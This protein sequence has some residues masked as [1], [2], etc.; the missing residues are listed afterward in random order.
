M[1]N[2]PESDPRKENVVIYDLS[3]QLEAEL[4]RRAREKNTSP[5][6]EAAK[7]LEGHV[8]GDIAD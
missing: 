6:S 7:I 3:P 2:S 8:D 5:E 4:V 1:S